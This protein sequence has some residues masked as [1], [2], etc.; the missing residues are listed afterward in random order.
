MPIFQR[1]IRRRAMLSLERAALNA[2]SSS[3]P[4]MIPDEFIGHSTRLFPKSKGAHKYK[5]TGIAAR[6]D[7]AILTDRINP[8]LH[9]NRHDADGAPILKPRFIFLSMRNPNFA[10]NEFRETILPQLAHPFVLISGSEDVTLPNQLD[11][12]FPQFGQ[13]ERE[14]IKHITEH[15]LLRRWHVENLDEI[16]NQKVSPLPIG[17][18][19]PISEID[20]KPIM[21]PKV[22]SLNSR[23]LKILCAHRTREGSQWQPRRDVT[24]LAKSKWKD[25]CTT[26]EQ[27]LSQEDYLRQVEQHAFVLCVQGGGLDPSP[28]AWQALLHGA[29]PIVRS[30]ALDAAYDKLPV[31]KVQDWRDEAVTQQKMLFWKNTLGWSFDSQ[32]GRAM[33]LKKLSL[34]YWWTHITQSFE[35]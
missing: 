34:D 9:I 24:M 28:K 1:L 35:Q 15:K 8:F 11:G 25:F 22:P 4:T 31:A 3:K 14:S 23:P 21:A 10:V 27:E 30:T 13:R 2:G 7:W 26:I 6:C 16:W 19:D 18:V 5:L 17:F 12:R 33:V 32:A 20:Q 29:I